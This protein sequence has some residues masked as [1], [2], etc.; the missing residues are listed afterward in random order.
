MI[1]WNPWNSDILHQN[2]KKACI[3]QMTAQFLE[4]FS[5]LKK[6]LFG[7]T[8]HFLS[9]SWIWDLRKTM[10]CEVMAKELICFSSCSFPLILVPVYTVIPITSIVAVISL[11]QI[12]LQIDLD[13]SLYY[14]IVKMLCLDSWSSLFF[15]Y[16]Q[17]IKVQR[18]Q[19]LFI[20]WVLSA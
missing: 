6:C 7:S 16:S 5:T 8:L 4:K 19:N 14:K 20:L 1:S 3:F 2:I 17:A 13:S 10:L 12:I 15:L 9:N 11:V 18:A